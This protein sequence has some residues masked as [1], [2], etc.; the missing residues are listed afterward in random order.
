MQTPHRSNG[1][2]GKQPTG[3]WRTGCRFSGSPS[4]GGAVQTSRT[5]AASPRGPSHGGSTPTWTA[6]WT[7]LP[8]RKAK[9]R[10][11]KIP[12]YCSDA[13]RRWVIDGPAQQGLDW[14]NWT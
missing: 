4:G 1:P 2:F 5:T 7:G 12:A 13:I 8:P 11:P 14:A 9:G 10:R 6:A 3:P